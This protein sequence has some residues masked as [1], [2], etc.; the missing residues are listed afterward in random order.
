MEGKPLAR[1]DHNALRAAKQFIKSTDPRAKHA[2]KNTQHRVGRLMQL[3]GCRLCKPQRL[4]DLSKPEEMHRLHQTWRLID[5]RLSLC[6]FGTT[7]E[8]S[9]HVGDPDSF[10]KHRKQCVVLQSDQMPVCAL[11]KPSQQLY[12]AHERRKEGK[13]IVLS[14][15]HKMTQNVRRAWPRVAASTR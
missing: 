5:E 4:V 15:Q 6:A 11:L 3:I 8:L 7:Q 9:G 12:A 14:D 13:K 2:E 1:V 10:I